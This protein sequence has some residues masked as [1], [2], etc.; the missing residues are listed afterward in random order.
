M[1]K[2]NCAFWLA[3]PINHTYHCIMHTCLRMLILNI[4]KGRHITYITCRLL[5]HWKCAMHTGCV[6]E[7]ALIHHVIRRQFKEP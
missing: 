1:L 6:L 2:I 7:K 3:T 4:G 5:W